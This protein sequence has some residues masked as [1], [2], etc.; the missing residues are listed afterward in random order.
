[1]LDDSR[2]KPVNRSAVIQSISRYVYQ[3][4]FSTY[5]NHPEWLNEKFRDQPWHNQKFQDKLITKLV[6][7]FSGTENKDELIVK[8]I[9]IFHNFLLPGFFV[10]S[11]FSQVMDN[12]RHI[13]QTES[14]SSGNRVDG[15]KPAGNSVRV[16]TES[17]NSAMAILLLD[18][19]NLSLNVETETFLAGCCTYPIRIKIAFANWRSMGKQDTEYHGRSYELIHVP[20]SKDSADIKMATVG[21]SIFLHY[22]TAKEVLIC[23]SDKALL[24]LRN[25]LQAQGLTVYLVRKQGETITF[26]NS[27]TGHTQTHTI[28]PIPAIDQFINQIKDLLGEEQKNTSNQWVKL[29]RISQLYQVKY[30]TEISQVV[31]GHLPGK[32]VQDFFMNYPTDFVLHQPAEKSEFYVT[33]FQPPPLPAVLE[34]QTSIQL[35][36]K[37][38]PQLPSNI[39]SKADLEQALVKIVI[40]LTA[41]SPGSDVSISNVGSEFHKQYGQPITQVMA[42]LQLGSKLP[43]FLLSCN[44]FKLKNAGKQYLVSLS[45][46]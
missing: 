35:T 22:P 30:K 3:V 2:L 16:A 24:H 46:I 12:L 33:L 17:S 21:A 7:K 10:S 14:A 18:A 31:A 39:T 20:A 23:S 36:G 40:A 32:K 19:E 26:V 1:M 34:T 8:T 41:K 43:K 15:S 45:Q 13:T 42:S 38:Q 5:Q 6:E 27:I 4:I 11:N 44:S 9:K 25:T 28:K 29:S 37:V